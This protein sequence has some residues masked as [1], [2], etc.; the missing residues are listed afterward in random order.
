MRLFLHYNCCFRVVLGN[1]G[2]IS[3][4]LL[5]TIPHYCCRRIWLRHRWHCPFARVYTQSYTPARVDF[6]PII[7]SFCE[8]TDN[9]VLILPGVL[10]ALVIRADFNC[11]TRPD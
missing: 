9:E 7:S 10:L 6:R 1:I 11:H 4:N 5:D 2:L 8:I 3:R